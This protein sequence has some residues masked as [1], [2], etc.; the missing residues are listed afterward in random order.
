[1]RNPGR[2]FETGKE[3]TASSENHRIEI[4]AARIAEDKIIALRA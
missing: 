2:S 3:V 1:M 4:V